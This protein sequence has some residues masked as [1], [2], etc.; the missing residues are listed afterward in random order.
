MVYTT[1]NYIGLELHE[2]KYPQFQPAILN[3]SICY[4]VTG[5]QDQ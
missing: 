2:G 5:C 1:T 3:K 4:A